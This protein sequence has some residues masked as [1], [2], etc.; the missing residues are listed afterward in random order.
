MKTKIKNILR[1]T[2]FTLN[3]VLLIFWGILLLWWVAYEVIFY[4]IIFLIIAIDLSILLFI[5][6][7]NL[8]KVIFKIVKNLEE[9]IIFSKKFIKANLV[10]SII[11]SSFTSMILL[12]SYTPIFYN[13]SDGPYLIWNDD[14]KT[15]ITIIWMTEEPEFG[16][17]KYGKSIDYMETIIGIKYDTLHIIKL[18]NLSPGSK[19]YF[20]IPG[21]SNK[22]Y[23]FKTAP[24]EYEDFSFCVLGDMTHNSKGESL[25]DVIIETMDSYDY[26]F[27][28]NTGDIIR[29]ASK[30]KSWHYFFN[31]MVEHGSHNPYIIAMGNWDYKHDVEGKKFEYFFPYDY[32]NP[33][34]HYYSF[35]YSNAHFII[36]ESFKLPFSLEVHISDRQ[37]RWLKDELAA[38]QDKWLFI[39]LHVPPYSTGDH[40]MNEKLISKLCSLFYMYKVDVVFSGHDHNYECFWV[41]RTEKW[42][43][44]YYFVTGGGGATLDTL[45]MY[46]S[47]NPWKN[48]WHNASIESYQND[49]VTVHNQLY[50]E[51]THHF[52]HVEVDDDNLHVK[53]IRANNS[54]IQELFIEK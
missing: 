15:T 14:P 37:F 44:T 47:K 13:Y 31:D 54:L 9:R 38:N 19:Y 33:P 24:K 11:L 43:G 21:F 17:L 4:M 23:K 27:I 39:I 6:C 30:Q 34:E 26:D 36:L 42:G 32:G 16:E 45:I 48:I 41:N 7:F 51:I 28:I 52:I 35:D 50:G 2:F 22:I 8:I 12:L 3:V 53:A 49:Y 10:L 1:A 18:K 46:R 40:N 29:D 20:T 5:L 25:Y